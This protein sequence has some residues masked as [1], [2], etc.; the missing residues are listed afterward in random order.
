M[1][2]LNKNPNDTQ[3][4]TNFLHKLAEIEKELTRIRVLGAAVGPG[5]FSPAVKEVNDLIRSADSL[6]KELINTVKDYLDQVSV[7]SRQST[8]QERQR[9]I[10]VVPFS[11][12]EG[13]E[14]ALNTILTVLSQFID[15]LNAEFPTHSALPDAQE[16]FQIAVSIARQIRSYER[17]ESELSPSILSELDGLIYQVNALGKLFNRPL[18]R[19]P[20]DPRNTWGVILSAVTVFAR[21][22]RAG[23]EKVLSG[24]S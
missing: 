8:S 11:A 4:L 13:A 20:P 15:Y 21:N 23:V 22:L 3:L 9:R 12:E 10:P 2:A 6:L 5:L 16:A 14:K 1:A 19:Y 24:G 17:G 7:K 18:Y